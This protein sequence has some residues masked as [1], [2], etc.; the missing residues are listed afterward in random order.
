MKRNHLFAS[1]AIGAVLTV[2]LPAQAQIL[3][4]GMH[5]VPC[6]SGIVRGSGSLIKTAHRGVSCKVNTPHVCR[7]GT[8]FALSE[9]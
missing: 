4:G 9:R 6:D 7:H 3:G 1:A 8:E 5:G 2:T